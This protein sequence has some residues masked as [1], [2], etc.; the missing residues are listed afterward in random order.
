MK[1]HKKSKRRRQREKLMKGMKKFIK[2][3]NK[4]KQH[5]IKKDKQRC[6]YA[7]ILYL[8]FQAAFIISP[9]V[10]DIS[11]Y[12]VIPIIVDYKRLSNDTISYQERLNFFSEDKLSYIYSN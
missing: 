9:S 2:Y 3:I 6:F 8:C 1:N 12:G 7:A 10:M 5:L 11:I 4:V